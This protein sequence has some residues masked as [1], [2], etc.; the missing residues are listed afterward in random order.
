M[1]AGMVKIKAVT[2][3]ESINALMREFGVLKIP[4]SK[5]NLCLDNIVLVTNVVASAS[6]ILVRILHSC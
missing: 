2:A 4:N 3:L 5:I 1:S 6:V